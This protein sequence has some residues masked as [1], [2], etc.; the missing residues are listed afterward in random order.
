MKSMIVQII[1][2]EIKSTQNIAET[3]DQFIDRICN[4]TMEELIHLKMYTPLGLDIAVKEEIQHEVLEIYRI[5]TYGYLS[6][7]SY[8]LAQIQIL[9]ITH[10]ESENSI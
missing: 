1:E 7:Q 6:L 3:A 5:K 8:R 10:R 2:E 4:L 9:E